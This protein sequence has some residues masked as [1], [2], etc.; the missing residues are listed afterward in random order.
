MNLAK[1][2]KIEAVADY[3]QTVP[4]DVQLL[5]EERVR[6]F[7]QFVTGNGTLIIG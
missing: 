5:N 2:L 7:S 4:P 6:G 1:V 3:E